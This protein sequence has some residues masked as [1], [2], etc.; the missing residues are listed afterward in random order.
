[1]AKHTG[2][3]LIVDWDV[4]VDLQNAILAGMGM[5]YR[6]VDPLKLGPYRTK[7]EAK[8]TLRFFSDIAPG[9]T[10]TTQVSIVKQE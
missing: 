2:W 1:M 9:L 7:K 8:D 6:K 4:P 10:V 5:S 3:V